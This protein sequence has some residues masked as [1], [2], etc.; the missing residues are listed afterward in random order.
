[1]PAMT[2]PA[3]PAAAATSAE[4]VSAHLRRVFAWMFVGLGLTTAIA[5]WFASQA[6]V[7]D[8]FADHFW[9]FIALMVAQFGLVFV[10]AL[11]INKLSA[12]MA[13][14]MFCLYAGLTGVTFSVLLEAY[15]TAS[16]VGAF[17]GA[18][19]LFAG[20]ALYGYATKRDLSSWGGILFGALIGLIVASIVYVF[21]GGAVF[22]LILGIFGVIIFSGLTAYDMQKI[23]QYAP[24][25][26]DE[27]G[28]RRAAIIGALALYLDFINLFISLLRIFGSTR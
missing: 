5:V 26:G 13:T 19:G 23:K 25:E 18:A 11:A 10:L 28:A 12:F 3:F 1:M 8:W 6:D 17:A 2:S 4:L 14:L 20:M 27:T 7:M 21:T 24:A 16:I 15:T 9:V 22:N